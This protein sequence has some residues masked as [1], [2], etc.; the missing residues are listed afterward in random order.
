MARGNPGMAEILTGA[1]VDTTAMVA[2]KF[3]GAACRA[4]PQLFDL[5]GNNAGRIVQAVII[6]YSCPVLDRCAAYLA[7]MQPAPVGVV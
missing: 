6:C 5:D 4:D 2:D 3:V 1:D 7:T